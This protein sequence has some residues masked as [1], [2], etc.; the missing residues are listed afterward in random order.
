[1]HMPSV[2]GLAPGASAPFLPMRPDLPQGLRDLVSVQ[3]RV[4]AHQ[5]R[6]T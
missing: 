6:W 5:N 3:V 1:M 4:Q 2:G